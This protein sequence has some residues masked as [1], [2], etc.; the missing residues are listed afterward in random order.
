M[1]LARSLLAIALLLLPVLSGCAK[2]AKT[3]RDMVATANPL[4]SAAAV[5]MLRAGAMRSMRRLPPSWCSGWSSRSLRG[6]AAVP[7]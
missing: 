5:E 2:S 3:P 1:T 4:A 6:S 7:F